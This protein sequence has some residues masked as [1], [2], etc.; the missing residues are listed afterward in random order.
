MHLLRRRYRTQINSN[1]A[2]SA[3]CTPPEDDAGQA[4][5]KLLR[6]H[7]DRSFCSLVSCGRLASLKTSQRSSRG[8]KN[9]STPQLRVQRH[10]PVDQATTESRA[11]LQSRSCLPMAASA[12]SPS[13]T[14]IRA[15]LS[16]LRAQPRVQASR[17]A[18][19]LQAVQQP[20]FPSQRSAAAAPAHSSKRQSLRVSFCLS[21]G[22]SRLHTGF[23]C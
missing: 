18:H 20:G 14:A 6:L 3:G 2:L 11:E 10:Q 16:A 4:L 5:S 13:C 22:C 19:K 15:G 17:R 23:G 7:S 9:V 12:A 21:F 8:L 1:A